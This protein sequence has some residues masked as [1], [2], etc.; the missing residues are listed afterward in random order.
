MLAIIEE[1]VAEGDR[2][3]LYL[4]IG[5]RVIAIEI[6]TMRDSRGGSVRPLLD[7]KALKYHR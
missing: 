6:P 1:G 4:A 5:I 2:Y 7:E 3:V